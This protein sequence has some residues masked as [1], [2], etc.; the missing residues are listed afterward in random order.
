MLMFILVFHG[1]MPQCFQIVHVILSRNNQEKV[2]E[3][4]HS[5]L[6]G[7]EQSPPTEICD[8]PE[9]LWFEAADWL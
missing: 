7:R 3:C 4:A 1:M 6:Y 9:I 2:E 5:P 8:M